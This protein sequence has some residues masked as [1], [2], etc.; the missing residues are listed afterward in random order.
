MESENES[1]SHVQLFATPG[2]VAC[3][4]PL[5]MEFSRPEYCSGL[6]C[7]PPGDL[8]N[9]GIKP[10]S[11]ALQVDSLLPESPEKP[12]NTEVGSPSLLQ[13][14][15]PIQELNWG[16]LL[17]C[18]WILNH[19]S[20]QGSYSSPVFKKVFKPLVG[21]ALQILVSIAT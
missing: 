18:R 6:S 9:P 5:S 12:K 16:C 4:S 8:P 13:Q 21:Y 20:H 1:L 7:P 2:S 3:Q 11:P 17:H 19:L 15:F 14:K 10:R